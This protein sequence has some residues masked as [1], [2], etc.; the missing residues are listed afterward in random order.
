[1]KTS[2][3]PSFGRSVHQGFQRHVGVGSSPYPDHRLF[4]GTCSHLHHHLHPRG[5]GDLFASWFTG[6]YACD[7]ACHSG[8]ASNNCP[9]CRYVGR[10]AGLPIHT[11]SGLH[12]CRC[13]CPSPCSCASG[14]EGRLSS[15]PPNTWED[16][17]ASP[18]S[19]KTVGLLPYTET[20]SCAGGWGSGHPCD[21]DKR[22]SC[23]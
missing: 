10:C 6:G 21:P 9:A 2:L 18:G 19:G 3:A 20:G 12:S 8:G 4:E 11:Q 15:Q 1:M 16:W 22:Q 17:S 14:T 23:P 7:T 5:Q 13:T